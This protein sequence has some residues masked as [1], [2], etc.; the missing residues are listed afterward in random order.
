METFGRLHACGGN[1]GRVRGRRGHV[2][3]VGNGRNGTC[4]GPRAEGLLGQSGGR[5]VPRRRPVAVDRVGPDRP[6]PADHR[7]RREGQRRPPGC[8]LHLRPAR[9]ARA[10]DGGPAVRLGDVTGTVFEEARAI[11][12]SGL[13]DFRAKLSVNLVGNPAMGA[14]EFAKTPRRTIVG[15]SL[16]VTAPTGQYDGHKLI[17]LGTNRWAFKPEIGVAV[18]KGRWDFDGYVGVWLFTDNDDFFPGGKSRS[19]DPVVAVQGHVSYTFKPRLWAAV[20]ATWYQGGGARVGR[21]RP[22]ARPEQLPPRRHRLVPDGQESVVEVRLQFRAFRADWNELPDAQRRL[23]VPSTHADVAG[24][25]RGSPQ[26]GDNETPVHPLRDC[27]ARRG[28]STTFTS[29]VAWRARGQ[30]CSRLPTCRTTRHQA[31]VC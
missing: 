25:S 31:G 12:R 10:G 20:D 3:G 23:P 27:A 19:Q 7:H 5:R 11:S 21:R 26:G 9:Q 6:D 22:I 28:L 24:D 1:V 8:G 30:G 29:A 18:P 13:T 15:T 17:N 4:A 16:T 14:R 2:P